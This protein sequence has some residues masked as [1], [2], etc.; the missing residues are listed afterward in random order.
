MKFPLVLRTQNLLR[1]LVLYKGNFITL[2]LN[3]LSWQFF[4]PEQEVGG[5]A[6]N[7]RDLS[8]AAMSSH[9]T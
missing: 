9:D 2:E 1:S 6:M 7:Y 4:L 5:S 3:T 8:G